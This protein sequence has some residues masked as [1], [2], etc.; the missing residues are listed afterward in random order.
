MY[1][2]HIYLNYSNF[3]VSFYI[4]SLCVLSSRAAH[5]IVL[6]MV[7]GGDARFQGAAKVQGINSSALVMEEERLV[8]KILNVKEKEELFQI[9]SDQINNR[10]IYFTPKTISFS[11]SLC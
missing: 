10:K 8:M 3:F 7:E 4:F 1:L 6:H 11:R 9:I 2:V 5:V